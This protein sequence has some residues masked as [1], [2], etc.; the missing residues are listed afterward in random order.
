[1]TCLL[2]RA[3]KQ[4]FVVMTEMEVIIAWQHFISFFQKPV[5]FAGNDLNN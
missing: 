5:T 2:Y 1:M 3:C 4:S